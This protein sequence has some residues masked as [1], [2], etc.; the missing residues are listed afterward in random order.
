MSIAQRRSHSPSSVEAVCDQ[1][2]CKPLYFLYA[3]P[4]ELG[5]VFCP[6]FYRHGAPKGLIGNWNQERIFLIQ[7][8]VCGIFRLADFLTR[9]VSSSDIGITRRFMW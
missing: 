6:G 2:G 4:T 3:A 1:K 9:V 8:R 5:G 7:N